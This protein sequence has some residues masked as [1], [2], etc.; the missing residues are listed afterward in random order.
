MS[1][2]IECEKQLGEK[3]YCDKC[4]K[5]HYCLQIFDIH[6]TGYFSTCYRCYACGYCSNFYSHYKFKSDIVGC[7]L[8]HESLEVKIIQEKYDKLLKVHE[9]LIIDYDNNK[10]ENSL[11]KDKFIKA[12]II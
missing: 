10:R 3:K 5:K 2:T 7:A 4:N 6:V 1:F 8:S 9:N 11:L 12:N